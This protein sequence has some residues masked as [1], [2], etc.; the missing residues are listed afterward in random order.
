MTSILTVNRPASESAPWHALAA[1]E[2]LA[3]QRSRAAGLSSDEVRARREAFGANAIEPRIGA[4]VTR[5]LW[6][7]LSNPL[8]Y[9]LIASGGLALLLGKVI[10]G[11]VVLG[12]VVLN[13][14]IGFVQ[15]FRARRAL[16]ALADQITRTATVTRDG[17]RQVV[18]AADLVPGDVVLL[19]P[20]DL[21]PADT[22]VLEEHGLQTI[23]A[24]LT[25][26]SAPVGKSVD[27]VDK[28][29]ALGD[30]TSM[31][32]GG[33]LIASGTASAL[34]VATGEST[35]LGRISHLLTEAEPPETPLNRTLARVGRRITAAIVAVSVLLFGVGVLRGYPLADAVLVAV[36][37]A[38]AAI[39]EGLPTIVTIALA[40]GVRR[41][42]ARRAIVRSLPAVET[43]GSTTV[44]CTDKTG[45]LTRNEMT[46]NAIWASG[47]SYQLGGAGY[48]P[49]GELSRDGERLA[50]A[51]R[52]V[53]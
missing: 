15:E 14:L 11:L 2:A 42:A 9:V 10:D 12:V 7:Q 4:G 6:R 13:T 26:E 49:S 34:V 33:T 24:S 25:G 44:I 16:A 52:E 48:A 29:A 53:E 43:L 35:E 40:I 46:V 19:Q 18:S 37:L 30:R 36:T 20:G 41:M 31:L 21:V 23:E 22:R 50:Q 38:V 17:R 27:P 1:D 28:S 45:T 5:L 3:A 8:I 39:P 47:V 32:Y 51:P